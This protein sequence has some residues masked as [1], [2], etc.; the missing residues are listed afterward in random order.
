MS[1]ISLKNHKDVTYHF[2]DVKSEKDNLVKDGWLSTADFQGTSSI[3]VATS[4]PV[5]K[6]N[7]DKGT[8]QK[9]KKII[10]RPPLKA[11][12]N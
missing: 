9:P 12:R 3:L 6:Q 11:P 4:T 10:V 1:K 7:L 8:K 2:L 5:V